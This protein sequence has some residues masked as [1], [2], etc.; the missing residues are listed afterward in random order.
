MRFAQ[1]RVPTRVRVVC[2][3]FHAVALFVAFRT[4]TRGAV[5]TL[6]LQQ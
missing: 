4:H 5:Q 1:L 2:A 3:Q 6:L